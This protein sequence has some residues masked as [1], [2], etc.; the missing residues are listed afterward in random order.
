V[1]PLERRY[2]MWLLAYPG[3]YRREHDEE[4]VGTLLEA[5]APG[6]EWP[7]AREAGALLTGGLRTRAR[8][9]AASPLR[10]W[11]D[12]LRLGVIVYLAVACA[13]TTGLSLH[14]VVFGTARGNLGYPDLVHLEAA[15]LAI[16]V[17]AL[18]WAAYEVGLAA[19]AGMV[20]IQ[21][22][23]MW[24]DLPLLG[25]PV[26]L[27][28]AGLALVA[29]AVA[30]LAWHPSLRPA[31]R[32]WPARLTALAL[33]AIALETLG[34]LALDA[35]TLTAAP[36]LSRVVV[37]AQPELL[38]AAAVLLLLALLGLDPR[39]A[40]AAT[41]FAAADAAGQVQTLAVAHGPGFEAA[42]FAQATLISLATA[43]L[44]LAVTVLSARRRVPI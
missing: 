43:A 32:P 37:V 34:F 26:A 14:Y 31:R 4:L 24:N 35:V 20:V 19:M 30:A 44:A 1:T 11:T 27:I 10:M 28:P 7:S 3:E 23:M 18:V 42:V 22:V 41:V 33:A 21:G 2:R 40:L 38:V 5:A 9:A 36:A 25:G 8:L 17:V 6:Q 16:G 29:A 13:G 39:P 15:V 12:G